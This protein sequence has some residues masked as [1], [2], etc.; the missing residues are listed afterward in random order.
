LHSPQAPA[1]SF[2]VTASSTEHL[3]SFTTEKV[4]EIQRVAIFA[5]QTMQLPP[6][7]EHVTITAA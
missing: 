7:Y 6:V 1:S 3:I 5:V 2:V 4:A